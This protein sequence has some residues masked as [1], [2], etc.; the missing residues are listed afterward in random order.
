MAGWMTVQEAAER[1]NL[2]TRRV[3]VLCKENRLPGV[4]R[5]GY[6][7]LI[8]AD[9]EKPAD[10]R[11]RSGAYGKATRTGLLPLPVGVSD[12]KK[13]V[14]DYYYVDKTLLIRVLLMSFQRSLCLRARVALARR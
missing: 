5:D 13:A 6:R 7:W 12:F 3:A 8:P 9:A 2:T 4:E 1:W 14:T 10:R 11:V